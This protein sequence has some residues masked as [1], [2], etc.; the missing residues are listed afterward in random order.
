[1]T[2]ALKVYQ[3]LKAGNLS[4]EHAQ[5]V[6]HAIQLSGAEKEMDFQ[7]F[8]RKE[9]AALEVRLEARIDAK[10]AEAKAELIRWMFLF[11]VG[12]TGVILAAFHFAK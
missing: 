5:A 2:N 8:V 1:M 12:Q 4:D 3:T 9:I 6:T 10:I 11:W 7:T